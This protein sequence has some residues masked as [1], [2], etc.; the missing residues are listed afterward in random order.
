MIS[1]RLI[2]TSKIL[3][4]FQWSNSETHQCDDICYMQECVD[5]ISFVEITVNFYAKN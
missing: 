2:A 1:L 4:L 5:Q 3:N